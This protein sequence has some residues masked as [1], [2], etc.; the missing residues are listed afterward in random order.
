MNEEMLDKIDRNLATLHFSE[1][2][3]A[4]R[5]LR[6]NFSRELAAVAAFMDD[7]GQ[8][9]RDAPGIPADVKTV[10]LALVL[11]DEEVNRELL[12]VLRSLRENMADDPTY[13]QGAAEDYVVDVMDG[14]VDSIYVLLWTAHA[15]G[16]AESLHRVWRKVAEKNASKAGAPKDPVTG[17]VLR[18]EGYEPPDIWNAVYGED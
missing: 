17:K 16:G 11:I 15:F 3:K 12:R 7:N 8:P 9:R 6:R 18:P 1:C 2:H 10:E 5:A 4:F 13:V 14:I